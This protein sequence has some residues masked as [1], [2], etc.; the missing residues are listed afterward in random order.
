MITG[1]AGPRLRAAMN[2]HPIKQDLVLVGGGH[3]HIEV[4]RRFGMRP[5]PGL[6]I[7]LVSRDTLTPY[8]GMLPGLVAGHYDIDATHID[9]APLAA[10]A[11]ARLFHDEVTGL[12]LA[13]KHVLCANRPPL[14]YD[15]L[16]ID[17]GSAPQAMVPGALEH[18]V[19]VKP[20]SRFHDHWEALVARVKASR[21]RCR[22]GV[23]GGGA[24]GTE[25]LMAA[26]A[27]LHAEIENAAERLSFHLVTSGDDILPTHNARV[28]RLYGVALDEAGIEVRAGFEVAEVL[29]D[30]V[31]DTGGERI[32]LDEILWVTQASA[33]EWPA[34][35]G[36]ATSPAGFIRVD[37][38]LRSVSC[39]EVFAAGDIAD[40]DPYPRPK[41]GVFAVRQGPPLADN[42]R[43][44]ARGET[45]RD[46]VPQ[47]RFL[48]L[49]TT[50][51]RHAI[52]SRGAFAAAGGWVWRWKDFIDQR[53]MRRYRE[54][55]EMATTAGAADGDPE[56][57]MRCGGCGAK[58]GA[59]VLREAL[60]GITTCRD[61]SIVLGVD[62]ADDAAV[63]RV[64]PG[65]LAVHTVDGF[66][67]FIDDP[68]MLG[69]VGANHALN[70]VYAM[71]AT[72][73]T[74]LA[75]ITLP[76]AENGPMQDDL[77]QVLRGAVDTFNA[78]DT[79]LVG[80]HTSE[81]SE[82]AAGFAING[83]VEP[84]SLV[85]KRGVQTGDRLILTQPLGTGVLFAAA[86]RGKARSAWIDVALANMTRSQSAA[87]DCFRRHG[88]HAMT[89]V[90]GFGLAGHVLEML[91]GRAATLHL[92][93]LPVLPGSLELAAARLLSTLHEE[94]RR[95]AL[96][97]DTQHDTVLGNRFEIAF[98][99]QTAGG[100]LG[101][102]P[103][104]RASACAAELESLGY[105]DCRIIGEVGAT[106]GPVSTRA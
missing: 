106:R 105:V 101:A 102:V 37:A 4:L 48:S 56:P 69:R 66:R 61:D 40:V 12:D 74:A 46:F 84:D 93:D 26:H 73:A 83:H 31:L 103:A 3:A 25:L 41:S 29:A 80:G 36:L 52:A 47:R 22:I 43:R 20:V 82:L 49:I 35:A 1:A 14:A 7:S 85:R 60:A 51:R 15:W 90:T 55:P 59:E 33:P 65:Q 53:F 5:E 87:A 64:P 63:V 9:L 10:F 32:P 44:A 94:N 68:W 79:V 81:G 99:P 6:R 23:V 57:D 58:I 78:A 8:S 98:D 30:A 18:A 91:D 16:S 86:M 42:L 92:A 67:A 75:M 13:A 50:G 17:T 97:I 39:P 76:F 24:G 88:V 38:T 72:P 62:A 19:P 54:L 45:L 2:D 70:D 28:R 21:A 77:V 27:R 95:A 34:A 104:E 71:G 11:G 89:D 100:L 96:Q